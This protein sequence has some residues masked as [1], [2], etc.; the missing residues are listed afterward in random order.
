LDQVP[1]QIDEVVGE[2]LELARAQAGVHR[3]RPERPV[4]GRKRR[5]K[6]LGLGRRG[7]ALAAATD[8]R[9]LNAGGRVHRHLVKRERVTVDRADRH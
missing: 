6:C 9:Q 5:Q 8:G 4:L 1:L 7:N 3:R 2:R